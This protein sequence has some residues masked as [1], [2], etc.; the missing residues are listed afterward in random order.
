MKVAWLVSV[1][2]PSGYCSCGSCMACVIKITIMLMV[3]LT[4]SWLMSA[5][6]P[7]GWWKL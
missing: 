2:L 4:V 6:L 3:V 5:E 7:L 1:E